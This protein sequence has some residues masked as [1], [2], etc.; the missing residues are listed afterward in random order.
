MPAQS[1]HQAVLEERKEKLM[2]E[3]KRKRGSPLGAALLL[4][5]GVVL[6]LNVLGVLDWSIWWSVLRMWPILL[7]AAGLELLLGR[8]RWGSLL[9]TILVVAVL[10]IAL[11]LAAAGITTSSLETTEIRQPLGDASRADVSINPG[12][13]D[14][15]LGSALESANL[16]EGTIRKGK[17]EEIQES[18]SQ[19]G[20]SALYKLST[21]LASWN[22][23]PGAI[24]DSRLWELGLSPAAA[25]SVDAEV[26]VGNAELDL[27]GLDLE[28]LSAEMGVGRIKVVLPA[29]GQFAANLSQGVGIVEI[30]VPRGMAVRIK[31]DTALAGRQLP[32]DLVKQEEIYTSPGYATAADRVEIDVGVAIGMLTVRYQE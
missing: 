2:E 6:L 3:K 25:L 20:G 15:R 24:D 30:I 5:I 12:V 1:A 32:D 18:L 14:L 19:Q 8:W 28:K 26:G 21:K 11:W 9:A 27:A 7:I 22:A 16:I 23:F 4:L 10:V 17:N 31:A 13:G 29:E